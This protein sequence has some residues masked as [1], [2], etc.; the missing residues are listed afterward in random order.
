MPILTPE[1]KENLNKFE[2]KNLDINNFEKK[3]FAKKIKI[4]SLITGTSPLTKFFGPDKNYVKGT[5][6]YRRSIL[7]LKT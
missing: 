1:M 7:V 4:A 2:L 3:M 6:L 5:P